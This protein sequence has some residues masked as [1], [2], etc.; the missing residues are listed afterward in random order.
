MGRFF[1][2]VRRLCTTENRYNHSG[3]G[4]Q[5]L[6]ILRQENQGEESM[7]DTVHSNDHGL[8]PGDIVDMS[9]Q[10]GSGSPTR[11]WYRYM[12]GGRFVRLP[13]YHALWLRL[14]KPFRR[15]S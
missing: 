5:I 7:S 4:L 3:D 9:V 13:W 6:P 10:Y 8:D 15:K 2:W 1:I 12:G 11:N 14:T